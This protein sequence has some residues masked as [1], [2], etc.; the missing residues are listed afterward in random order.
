[1]LVLIFLW[2]IEIGMKNLRKKPDVLE[3]LAYRDTWGKGQIASYAMMYERL[4]LMRDLLADDG[5]IYVHCDWRVNSYLRL[6][7]DEIF[8]EFENQ[9]CWKR[10]GIATN[11]KNQWRNSHDVILFYSKRGNPIFNVQYG[12]YSES[13][14]EP[15]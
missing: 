10:S 9:I 13:S 7:M 4:K 5:S 2:N 12:E 1:M 15:L 11:V 8:G 6:I 14:N 3:E